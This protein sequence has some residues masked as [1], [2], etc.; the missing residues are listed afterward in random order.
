MRLLEARYH[1]TKR[2]DDFIVVGHVLCDELHA[3]LLKNEAP[4]AAPVPPAVM[5]N[6]KYLILMSSPRPFETLR[7]LDSLFWSFVE[8]G[9]RLTDAAH[10]NDT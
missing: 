7:A 3:S 9:I 5:S 1:P 8:V 6:F 10:A 2:R 4:T